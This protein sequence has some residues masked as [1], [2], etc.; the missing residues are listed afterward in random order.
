[1][2]RLA[3][4]GGLRRDQRLEVEHVQQRRLDDL[5]LQDRPGD[6][7]ERLVGEDG[8]P[9]GDRVDVEA[10]AQSAEVVEERALEQRLAV[11]AFERGEVREVIRR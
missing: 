6:A 3:D 9:F 10:E 11:V 1:M 8:G 7:H 2:R 4:A 5:R